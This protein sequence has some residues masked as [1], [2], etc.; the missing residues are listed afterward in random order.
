[1]TVATLLFLP[2]DDSQ[3]WHWWR[4]D[5]DAVVAEGDGLPDVG[6]EGHAS[7]GE[8]IAIAPA[9]AVTLHWADQIG[10]AHV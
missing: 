1:M 9:D 10:R 5:G 6:A 4:V 2:P 7:A 8:V 3:P